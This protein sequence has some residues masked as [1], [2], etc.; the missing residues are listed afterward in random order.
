ME[1]DKNFGELLEKAKIL[2]F[3]DDLFGISDPS[4]KVIFLNEKARNEFSVNELSEGKHFCY[5]YFNC[6]H[7]E[8]IPKFCPGIL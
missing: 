7:L 3:V 2:D 5:N 6:T 1:K 4:G 8:S